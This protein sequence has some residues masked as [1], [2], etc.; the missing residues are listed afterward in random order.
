VNQAIS[1]LVVVDR[2]CALK[3]NKSTLG[4]LNML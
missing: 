4:T 2:H 1:S 3:N